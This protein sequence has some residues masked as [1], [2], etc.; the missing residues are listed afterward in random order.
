MT[1]NDW[2]KQLQSTMERHQEAAPDGLWTDIESRLPQQQTTRRPSW[3]W[4]RIAASAAIVLAVMGTGYLLWP[5]SEHTATPPSI[6]MTTREVSTT[7]PQA[8][9]HNTTAQPVAHEPSPSHHATQASPITPSHAA[10]N[11]TQDNDHQRGIANEP[12][13]ETSREQQVMQERQEKQE[14]EQPTKTQPQ[15]RPATPHDGDRHHERTFAQNN[16]TVPAVKP[17]STRQTWSLGF[18][19]SNAIETRNTS[20]DYATYY[21]GVPEDPIHDST[22]Q[23]FDSIIPAQHA[24]HQTPLSLGVNVSVQLTRR[25]ALNTGVVYTRLKSD[26]S[27]SEQT[28]H[29]VGVPLGVTYSLWHF[30]RLGIYATAGM[31]ADFN[32]KATIKRPHQ[33][34]SSNISR[35]RM[36]LSALMGP[37]LQLDLTQ[38]L[39]IYCEPTMR[40]YFDNG[41]NVLNYF[42][43]KPL[44]FNL[45]AGLRFTIQ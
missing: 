34:G 23:P 38:D 7:S 22:S 26:I 30:K 31:Q 41:S 27:H 2:I 4:R 29:Y 8:L 36:Q 42:K 43:D 18:Y 28:L 11:A 15:H 33:S 37:G 13:Q 39:S 25:L 35:D 17:R 6:T 1:D 10:S 24:E 16:G 32:V 45:N 40:Y 20:G 21:N 44:N 5:S 9:A 12:R 19:A 14:A 3:S